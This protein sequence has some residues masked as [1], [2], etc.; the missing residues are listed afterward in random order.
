MCNM[1]HIEQMCCSVCRSPNFV[2]HFIIF[3]FLYIFL[4]FSPFFTFLLFIECSFDSF[5]CSFIFYYFFFGSRIFFIDNLVLLGPKFELPDK[6]INKT[7]LFFRLNLCRSIFIC[8]LCIWLFINGADVDT[9]LVTISNEI[10][11]LLFA[12]DFK[13]VVS[14]MELLNLCN[15][16]SNVPHPTKQIVIIRQRTEK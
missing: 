11:F 7:A 4:Q 9:S 8:I 14:F 12:V 6:K 3:F 15:A 1:I 2:S 5:V 16:C 13:V 10:F